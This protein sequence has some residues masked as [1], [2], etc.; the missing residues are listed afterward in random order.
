MTLTLAFILIVIA[1]LLFFLAAINIPSPI[2][3]GWLGM[4]FYVG[5]T[6]VGKF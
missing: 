1:L 5:S 3:L 6:L 4:F 2:S